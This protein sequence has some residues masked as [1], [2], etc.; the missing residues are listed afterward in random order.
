MDYLIYHPIIKTLTEKKKEWIV[1]DVNG[2]SSLD[3]LYFFS[4]NP[5]LNRVVSYGGSQLKMMFALLCK[6]H[7]LQFINL[8]GEERDEGENGIS[9]CD[10]ISRL[11]YQNFVCADGARTSLLNGG[12][13]TPIGIF[14]CPIT[15][16]ARKSK[17]A[18][19]FD[20]L[21][22]CGDKEKIKLHSNEL[23]AKNYSFK[24]FDYGGGLPND[25]KNIYQM[26]N[27]AKMIISDSFILDKPTR[28]LNKHLFFIGKDI[29]DCNNLGKSTHIVSKKSELHDYLKKSWSPLENINKRFGL[30]SLIAVL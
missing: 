26:L 6:E 4:K 5:R 11:A 9:F 2:K 17:V 25:W 12:I 29:L 28:Y 16:L 24:I 21:Y 13:E 20:I 8:H 27:G 10:I 18:E 19:T 1:Y 22:I 3:V 7:E 15:N 30:Q 23:T 14:E